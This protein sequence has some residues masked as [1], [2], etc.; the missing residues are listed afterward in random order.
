MLLCFKDSDSEDDV[1]CTQDD[2]TILTSKDSI[3]IARMAATIHVLMCNL[4]NTIEG[5]T[6][7]VPKYVSKASVSV[8]H[9]LYMWCTRQK[10]IFLSVSLKKN[11]QL[12][13]DICMYI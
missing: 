7:E 9:V 5:K 13:I 1:M 4:C 11:N 3:Y 10:A 8:A 6:R 12:Y 2:V